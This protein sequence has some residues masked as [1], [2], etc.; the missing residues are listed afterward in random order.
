MPHEVARFEYR[1]FARELGLVEHRMRALAGLAPHPEFER[2]ARMV[3]GHEPS[4]QG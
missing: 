1:V 3:P 2:F 4:H